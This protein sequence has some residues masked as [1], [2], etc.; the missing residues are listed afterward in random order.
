[1]WRRYRCIYVLRD[2]SIFLGGIS[3]RLLRETKHGSGWA[4]ATAPPLCLFLQAW[5]SPQAHTRLPG[6]LSGCHRGAPG[7]GFP[8]TERS[9]ADAGCTASPGALPGQSRVA[10]SPPQAS[11]SGLRSLSSCC[12]GK[13]P[14]LLHRLLPPFLPRCKEGSAGDSHRAAPPTAHRSD[15]GH[16]RISVD[17]PPSLLRPRREQNGS[18]GSMKKPVVKHKPRLH[19][20]EATNVHG[21]GLRLPA[22]AAPRLPCA[23]RPRT[24]GAG[25]PPLLTAVAL[26]WGHPCRPQHS[27]LG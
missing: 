21:E 19:L 17:L 22:P 12:L 20:C 23:H 9:L 5:L 27:P 13:A 25:V 16:Q 8:V 4:L 14:V 11:A 10:P 26:E 7:E 6:A 18:Q 2:S 15:L 1:M 3:L 24:A